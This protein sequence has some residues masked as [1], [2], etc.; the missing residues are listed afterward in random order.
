[1]TAKELNDTQAAWDDI[2]AGFDE[3]ATP[4]TTS[5]AE[6]ALQRVHL[7]SGLRFLDVAAGSGALSLPAARLGAE[8]LATD[9]S[10]AMVELLEARARNENLTI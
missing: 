9:I 4:L 6:V 5:F 10:P 8:V 3:Y 2:A 1:M 7:R